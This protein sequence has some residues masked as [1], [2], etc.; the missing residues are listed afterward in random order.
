[1]VGFTAAQAGNVPLE[2]WDNSDKVIDRSYT[3]GDRTLVKPFSFVFTGNRTRE[4]KKQNIM[5]IYMDKVRDYDTVK[6][7]FP[8][9]TD[10]GRGRFC[11]KALTAEYYGG[12]KGFTS[13]TPNKKT[14]KKK[15]EDGE[16]QNDVK[17]EMI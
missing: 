6:D 16:K 12:D 15:D 8:I 2:I 17:T 10:Y 9:V 4:E 13:S 1:M 5:R 14:R 11:D 7:T 3:E